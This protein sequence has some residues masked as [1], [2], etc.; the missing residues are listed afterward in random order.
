[1]DR[2][3]GRYDQLVVEA[4][5]R[6]LLILEKIVDTEVATLG[7]NATYNTPIAA[8]KSAYSNMSWPLVSVQIFSAKKRLM[9]PLAIVNLRSWNI[10]APPPMAL[11]TCL[12]VGTTMLLRA[13]MAMKELLCRIIS[14]LDSVGF[15]SSKHPAKVNCR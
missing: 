14:F 3:A 8:I 12:A 15:L 10:L 6:V 7:E 5:A 11:P 4:V 13:L 1:M 9:R 2:S